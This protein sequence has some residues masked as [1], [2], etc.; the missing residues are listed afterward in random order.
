MSKIRE[1][2][3]KKALHFTDT[4]ECFAKVDDS[5]FE[6]L[7]YSGGVIKDHW[8]WGD[9]IINVQGM[10]FPKAKIPI[11]AQHDIERKIGFSKK[12]IADDKILFDQITYL[13]NE[14]S[15]AFR[16]DSIAGFPFEASIS[17]KPTEVLRLEKG[18][19]MTVNGKNVQ[20]PMTVWNKAVFRECSVC[21]FGADSNTK[22]K[23]FDEKVDECEEF[24]IE[25]I[26]APLSEGEFKS[27]PETEGGNTDM[28]L[29]ELKD[30]H[31]DLVKEI[32]D[33]AKAQFSSQDSGL[34]IVNEELSAKVLALSNVVEAQGK[35]ILQFDKNEEIRSAQELK[36][37]A[38][39]LWTQ[40]L[41][42]SDLPENL[43]G[44][45]RKM[46]S[47]T[48]FMK[49][50]GFDVDAFSSAIDAEISDW[51][52]KL[53]ASTPAIQGFGRSHKSDDT[54]NPET[55]LEDDQDFADD[56]LSRVGQSTK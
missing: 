43:F 21:V 11:L 28:K 27:S 48:S 24:S 42:G 32:M 10:S 38:D 46:V 53:E 3:P 35:Q 50:T 44:K 23:A 18:A 13:D 31:P 40:R 4:G 51:S 26:G 7:G 9:L 55:E 56:M 47:H 15:T 37:K 30:K 45:V 17:A 33:E 36:A 54:T 49:E 34:K 20:G 8:W 12:P 41:A 52:S 5:G 6:M 29:A 39:L 25:I 16:N 19:K 2:I 1:N 14:H 22:S